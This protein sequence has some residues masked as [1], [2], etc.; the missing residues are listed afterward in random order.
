M[1]RSLGGY[2]VV[3]NVQMIAARVPKSPETVA[4]G[5]GLAHGTHLERAAV[6][7]RVSAAA[8]PR[9]LRGLRGCSGRRRLFR[10]LLCRGHLL[11][12]QLLLQVGHQVGDLLLLRE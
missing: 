9:P 11:R 1:V 8:L 12:V 7:G 3:T 6:R 2:D 10:G 5:M 4:V